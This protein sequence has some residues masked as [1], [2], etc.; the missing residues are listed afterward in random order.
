MICFIT[1]GCASPS[2]PVATT[3]SSM[4]L[5]SCGFSPRTPNDVGVVD[6]PVVVLHA[7]VGL[8]ILQNLHHLLVHQGVGVRH[9]NIQQDVLGARNQ[10]VIQ[11][12]GAQRRFRPPPRRACRRRPVA[13]AICARP[14]LRI[15]FETSAKSTFTRSLSTVMISAIPLAAE[16][17]MSSALPKACF[18]E[19]RP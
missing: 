11:Q 17:R 15:T 10:V 2:N 9:R 3:T 6:H 7:G 5:P 14:L 18:S 4:K 8:N 16:A 1:P 12:R 19:R 13:T